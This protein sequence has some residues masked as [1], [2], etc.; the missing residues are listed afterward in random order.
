[1]VPRSMG[2][3]ASSASSTPASVTGAATSTFT[4]PPTRASVRKWAGSTTRTTTLTWRSC[5]RAGG[6]RGPYRSPRSRRAASRRRWTAAGGGTPSWKRLRLHRDHR[7]K[8]PHD[9]LPPVARA[10]GGVDL[11]AGGAEIDAARIE[12][13]D[14]HG[15]AQHVHVTVVLGQAVGER[16]P[17]LPAGAAA[18]HPEPPVGRI[19]LGVALDRHHV[20]RLG[21]VGVHVDGESEVARQVAAHL[22][23]RLARVVAAHDVP[24]LLHEQYPGARAVHRDAVDAVADLGGRV[25]D[26][27]GVEAAVDRPPRPP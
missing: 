5:P 20:D 27:L 18:V 22:S 11:P 14:R 3:V 26:A 21:L 23:P 17:L 12:R 16:L 4:S 9:G 2:Y 7:G 1:M 15:V 10:R 25:R 19:V 8:V 6:V 24:V 13:I